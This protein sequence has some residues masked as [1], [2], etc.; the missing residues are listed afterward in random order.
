MGVPVYKKLGFEEVG[1]LEM[2]LKEFGGHGT[3]VHGE[4]VG[5]RRNDWD[6][7]ANGS[8]QWQ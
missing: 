8:R 7:S 3:H 4:F 6:E 1:R 2:D 5:S